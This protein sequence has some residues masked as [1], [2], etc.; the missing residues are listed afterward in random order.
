M[1]CSTRWIMMHEQMMTMRFRHNIL[2]S[3][4]RPPQT[5]F[6]HPPQIEAQRLSHPRRL[7]HHRDHLPGRERV[8]PMAEHGEEVPEDRRMTRDGDI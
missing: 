2:V 4:L 3:T 7:D 5:R 6:I 8:R 1:A